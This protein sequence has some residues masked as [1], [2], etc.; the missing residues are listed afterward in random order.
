M[1][2]ATGAITWDAQFRPFGEVHAITG[3]AANDR[4]FPGR[5]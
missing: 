1:T 4:R 3:T 5:R 2:D